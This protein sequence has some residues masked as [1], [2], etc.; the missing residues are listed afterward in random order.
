[1]SSQLWNTEKIK[2]YEKESGQALLKDEQ[3]LACFSRDFGN[4]QRSPPSAVCI[5]KD[6]ESLQSLLVFSQEHQ[7]PVTV[8]AHGFSQCGQAL[9]PPGG[10]TLSMK[11]FT[12]ALEIQGESI[13]VQANASWADLLSLSLQ[14]HKAPFVLPYNCHLS[15]GGVLSTGGVGASSFK[16]GLMNAYVEALEV[17]DGLGVKQVV[18]KNSPLFHACL[19]GQG[20]FAIITKACIKLRAVHP[21]VKTFSLVYTSQEQWFEDMEKIKDQVDYME[22]FC[23]PAMQGMQSRKGQKRPIASWLYGLHVSMEYEKKAN[24]LQSVISTLRPW[25]IINTQEE[26]IASYFLRHDARFE[27]MKQLGLWDMLHPWYECFIATKV[28]KENLGELLQTLPLHYA[29]MVHIVPLAKKKAGF[30]MLPEEDSICSFMILNPGV[31]ELF[32]ETCLEVIREL[33]TFFLQRGGKRYLSGFLGK[34]L[35]ASYWPDHYGSQ[36]PLWTQLKKQLDPAGI[37]CSRLYSNG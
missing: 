18:N 27:S 26:S 33:D 11:H 15:V 19:S 28:L 20:Q 12:K 32:K 16:Q 4:I 31:P 25:Q 23:S 30:L 2:Q 21:Q 3:T 22:L 14:Q 17:V 7:L 24:I 8:R 37:F 1:M 5:P 13:W 34:D 36:Y 29:N 10:L 35:P 9:A 6:E